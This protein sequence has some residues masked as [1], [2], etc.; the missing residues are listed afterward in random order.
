MKQWKLLYKMLIISTCILSIVWQNRSMPQTLLFYTSHFEEKQLVIEVGN[1]LASFFMKHHFYLKI[2]TQ[3]MVIQTWVFDRHFL[4]NEWNKPVTSREKLTLFLPV[5]KFELSSKN[6]NFRKTCNC[7][8]EIDNFP[9]LK[10]FS[11]EFSDVNKC[12]FLYHIMKCVNI[13]KTYIIQWSNIFQ[14]TNPWQ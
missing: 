4:G 3:A 6:K 1:K 10:S 12:N 13:G 11:D 14:L 2:D 9:I 5:I 7:L 8:N